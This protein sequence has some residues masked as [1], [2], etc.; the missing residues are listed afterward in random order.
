M[1]LRGII[2]DFWREQRLFEQRAIAAVVIIATLSLLLVGRLVWL[3]VVRYDYYTD[4]SQGNR[5]RI[6]PLPA[7][8]G[9]IYDRQGLILAENQPAYQLELV[10]EQV[11]DLDATLQGLVRIGLLDADDVDDAKRTVRSRRPQS[12]S[13]FAP[14]E[15]NRCRS[16]RRSSV[17]GSP[18]IR[19]ALARSSANAI[20]EATDVRSYAATR[21]ST[22]SSEGRS[23]T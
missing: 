17:S 7:P 22:L 1:S 18:M 15:A 12:P 8:R 23:K 16:R 14:W 20:S 10:P 11:P 21:V 3:Q 13:G 19:S 6:E 2:K 9:I 5:V 4:L